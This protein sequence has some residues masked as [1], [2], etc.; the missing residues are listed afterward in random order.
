MDGDPATRRELLQEQLRTL[1][2]GAELDDHKRTCA[3]TSP[4]DV[5]ATSTGTW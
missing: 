4:Y 5:C 3:N 1:M 2:R